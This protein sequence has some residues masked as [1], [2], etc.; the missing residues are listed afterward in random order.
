MP[1]K[2]VQVNTDRGLPYER[3]LQFGPENL[4]EAELLAVILRTGTKE[5]SAVALAEKVLALA[6]YPREGLL[7]LHDVS[8]EE[9]MEIRGIGMVKAVK[10]KC[11]AELSN[12]MS[13]AKAREGI[14]FTRADHVA[15][16]FME[17]LRH[18]DTECVYL[19]C[20][21]AKGHLLKEIILSIGTVKA[22]MLSPR[23]VFVEALKA[24]AVH[25][26]L[27]HNHP[28]G[29]PAPSAADRQITECI[30]EL[31]IKLD[32]PLIDHIIIGDNKYI[33]FKEQG[34]L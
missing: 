6:T 32:I 16:Y 29:D 21:D 7:G 12:R 8:V 17:K 11:I 22:S 1:E 5:D 3:F 19:L 34:F 20:L 30:R 4:T 18:R 2:N 24:E 10:L 25:I 27:L 9:L 15:E 13:R 14:C 31:G 33:I 26:L 28:S 23:E